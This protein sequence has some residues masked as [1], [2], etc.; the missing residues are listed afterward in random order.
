VRN[1]MTTNVCY[2]GISE[3]TTHEIE[4]ICEGQIVSVGWSSQA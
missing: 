3:F 1:F 4:N 2:G